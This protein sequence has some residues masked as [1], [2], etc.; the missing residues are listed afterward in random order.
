MT[1]TP[2]LM[3]NRKWYQASKPE[4]EFHMI[5]MLYAVLP[6][7]ARTEK[8]T[9]S[10]KDNCILTKHTRHLTYPLCASN[11]TFV[12]LV[13]ILLSDAFPSEFLRKKFMKT[14]LN[15]WI[16]DHTL[17]STE[18]VPSIPSAPVART[19]ASVK[20]AWHTNTLSSLGFGTCTFC[21]SHNGEYK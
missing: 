20:Q 5:N 12:V 9:F 18:P 8:T 7:R 14:R 16:T 15:L 10:C 11:T 6:L 2:Q 19:I 21:N 1:A 13:Y 17:R 4:M 3:L